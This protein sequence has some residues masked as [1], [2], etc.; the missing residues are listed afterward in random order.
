MKISSGILMYRDY[1]E[2]KEYLLVRPGGPYYKNM[3]E[4][5]WSI[6]KGIVKQ[7]ESEI[8]AAKRE[9]K[10]ET[11]QIIN[12]ELEHI[13]RI[14]LRKSKELTVYCIKGNFDEKEIKSNTFKMEY[15][16]NSGIFQSFPEI[17]MGGWFSYK[18]AK[19]LIHQK[20]ILFLDEIEKRDKE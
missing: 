14:K 18:K 4:G 1:N 17:E 2:I 15:P 9:F 6:P 19:V 20:L 5:I 11:G 8:D 13:G 3:N 12:G 10:E 16:K 7:G